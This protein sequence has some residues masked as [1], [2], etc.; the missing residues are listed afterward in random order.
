[1]AHLTDPKTQTAEHRSR[2][3]SQLGLAGIIFMQVRRPSPV[4][5]GPVGPP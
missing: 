1:M 4:A 3:I 2:V 5:V